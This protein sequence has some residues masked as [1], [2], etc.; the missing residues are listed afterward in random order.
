MIFD[1]FKKIFN[2]KEEEK[3]ENFDKLYKADQNVKSED[4]KIVEKIPMIKQLKK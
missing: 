4:Y 2:K 3:P 1:F